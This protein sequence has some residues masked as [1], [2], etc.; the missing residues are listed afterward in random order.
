[1]AHHKRTK[2]NPFGAGRAPA[3]YRTIQKRIP[4]PLIEEVN[5]MVEKF[6]KDQSKV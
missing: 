2:K 4:E 1:M 5:R 6:K 3:P